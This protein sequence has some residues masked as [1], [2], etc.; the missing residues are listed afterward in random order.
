MKQTFRESQ[1]IEAVYV[2]L[3]VFQNFS[4]FAFIAH[5]EIGLFISYRKNMM[6]C[7]V[8]KISKK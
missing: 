2:F 6:Y 1:A 8:Y 7:N 3:R 4:V 5:F